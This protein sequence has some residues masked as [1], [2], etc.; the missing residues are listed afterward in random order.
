MIN[1]NG[2]AALICGPQTERKRAR[3]KGGKEQAAVKLLIT[4]SETEKERERETANCSHR[5]A[6]YKCL[7]HNHLFFVIN[8]YGAAFTHTHIFF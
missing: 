5:S 6:S 8:C 1:R 3:E 7:L 4:Q 2:F